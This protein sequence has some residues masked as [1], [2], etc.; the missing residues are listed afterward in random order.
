MTV[1]FLSSLVKFAQMVI[2]PF[3]VAYIKDKLKQV[4]EKPLEHPFNDID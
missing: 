3:V 4:D 2:T 1:I